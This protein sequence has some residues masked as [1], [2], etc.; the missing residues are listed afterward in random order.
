MAVATLRC[1]TTASILYTLGTSPALVALTFPRA[2]RDVPHAARAETEARHF[3]FTDTF[4]IGGAGTNLTAR[5]ENVSVTQGY[6]HSTI[7]DLRAAIEG[8][9]EGSV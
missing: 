8:M 5:H 4:L 3:F 9:V 1:R 6:L 7:D 2:H